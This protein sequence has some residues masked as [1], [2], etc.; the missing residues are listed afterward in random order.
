M[1]QTKYDAIVNDVFQALTPKYM[2]DTSIDA[3]KA[4]D[5]FKEEVELKAPEAQVQ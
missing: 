1:V 5:M 4:L 3:A 2:T